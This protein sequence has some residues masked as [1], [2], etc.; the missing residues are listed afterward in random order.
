MTIAFNQIPVNFRVPGQYVEF[1]NSQANGS[2]GTVPQ[3]IL[4][5]GQMLAAGTGTPNVATLVSS[6][7]EVALL[8]GR[9]SMLHLMAKKLFLANGF[10]PTY[11]LAQAD[12]G[13]STKSTRTVTFSGTATAGGELALYIG[14]ARYAV[15][16]A[17]ATT[18]AQLATL[19]AAAI[20]ADAERYVDAAVDGGVPARVNLTAR[21]GGI[22][23]GRIECTHSR[24]DGERLPTGI[25]A[26]IAALVEG[27]G[28]PTLTAAIAGLG[29]NWYP[30]I[31]MPYTDAASL[32]ALEAELADRFGPVRQ[33]E[34]YAHVGR[35]ADQAT[36]QALAAGRNSPHESIIDCLDLLTPAWAVA[37]SVA[38][39]DAG[40]PD[41]ARPRQT[42]TLPGVVA[43]IETG[44]RTKQVRN[45]LLN[46]GVSTVLVDAGGL[47][48][49]ERLTTTYRLNSYGLPDDSYFDTESLHLL[50]NLRFT[51]RSRFA[52]KYPRHK[53][54]KDG[55]EGPNVMTPG[56]ARA[57]L[58]SLYRDWMSRGWVEGG[59]AFEQF[60]SDLRVEIDA[61]DP[62]RLNAIVPPDLI[63]QLRVV[64]AQIQFRR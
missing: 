51:L 53:L 40:E 33:I 37:A 32:T 15:P 11:I 3:K 35:S 59:T 13:G 63:N 28:N 9:G 22:D 60:K 25:S 44:R 8:A 5:I 27:A 61:D 17:T 58:I 39:V 38:A 2:D 23:A 18:A 42:L 36:L 49:I 16:V 57:E 47:V 56:T 26:V 52:A 21:H 20:T 34:G 41:P 1:D 4:L 29:E 10:T 14:D 55:S 48:H 45:Q 50:S 64:A 31:V 12:A 7:D 19:V 6:A 24:Y 30:T 62:N 46:A 43:K 54:G